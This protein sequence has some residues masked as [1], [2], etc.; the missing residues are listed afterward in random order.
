MCHPYDLCIDVFRWYFQTNQ[1]VEW[2]LREQRAVFKL[3]TRLVQAA[4]NSRLDE[5]GLKNYFKSLKKQYKETIGQNA[6]WLKY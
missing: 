4:R 2:E 3:A 6:V 1:E 5:E